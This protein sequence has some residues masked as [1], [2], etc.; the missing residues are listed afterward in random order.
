MSKTNYA[1]QTTATT[2]TKNKSS[3]TLTDTSPPQAYMKAHGLNSF[4]DLE[5]LF[6]QRLLDMLSEQNTSY[7][8]RERVYIRFLNTNSVACIN[9]AS[10]S[11]IF[12][13]YL[14][15]GVWLVT[16]LDNLRFHMSKVSF[17]VRHKHINFGRKSPHLACSDITC[18][19]TPGLAG[20][21]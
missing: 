18:G 3:R 14:Y 15:A 20:D 10:I 16:R 1:L 6:E 12:I 9:V 17:R 19:M 7:I 11:F 13:S 8:V 4:A 5:T 21:L 2:D